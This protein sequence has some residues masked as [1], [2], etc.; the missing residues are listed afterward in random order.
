MAL[1]NKLTAIADSIRAKTGSTNKL[2]LDEMPTAISNISSGGGDLP[3][4]ALNITGS[5]RI[6]FANG[7]WDWFI[8]HY[9]NRVTTSSITDADSMFSKSKVTN[10][11]FYINLDNNNSASLSYTFNECSNL[12]SPPYITGK[13]SRCDRMFFNCHRLN[14]IPEDW[15]TKIDWS[16][17]SGYSISNVFYGCYSL[18]KIPQNL[19]G[20]IVLSNT[21]TSS[22]HYP[23]DWQY[24]NCYVLE[25]IRNIPVSYRSSGN[26]SGL[27]YET[28]KNCHRLKS[29]T[30]KTNDNGTPIVSKWKS[31]TINISE[32]V[33]YASDRG[34]ITNFN[35]GLT[36]AT[37]ITDDASYQSLKNNPDSWTT[38]IQYSRYNH[39]SAV[40]TIN[41]LPD[42]SAYL[43]TDGGTNTIKFTG[44]SGSATDGGA[45]NTLT[46]AEIAVATAK[47]WTV[48]IV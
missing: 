36:T 32:Y 43:A 9:G 21:G 6:M 17:Q 2:T 28:F 44:A 46:E 29:L 18:K 31:Q 20:S 23:Y 12:E 45:I 8:N 26:T 5:C 42:T 47:G 11:P 7:N 27:F 33:G 40:E 39:D 30:F 15:A 34:Y 35:S 37:Q 4:E 1:T 24:T 41:S 22:S 19:I 13:I 25:E 14:Y 3:E 38:L 10:I 16:N 48:S